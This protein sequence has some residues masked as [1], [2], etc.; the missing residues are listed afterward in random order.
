MA[1]ESRHIA[2]VAKG[3]TLDMY[4]EVKD[5]YNSQSMVEVRDS[6]VLRDMIRLM[7]SSV[8]KKKKALS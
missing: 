1:K 2:I 3:E 6:D 4:N 8:R 7:H 5:Y